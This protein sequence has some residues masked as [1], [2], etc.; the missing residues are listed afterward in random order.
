MCHAGKVAHPVN[1]KKL[2][3]VNFKEMD[4]KVSCPVCLK[5]Y[6]LGA[7]IVILK[8]CGH[9]ICKVCSSKFVFP[10]SKKEAKKPTANE[11]GGKCPVCETK[12]KA[13]QLVQLVTEGT[14]FAAKG[15]AHS[16]KETLAFQ[17]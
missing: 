4:G 13:K 9:A 7:E 10:S 1:I 5:G 6:E 14:G 12:C 15:N 11:E 3:Q 16:T 2:V 17:C 8:V